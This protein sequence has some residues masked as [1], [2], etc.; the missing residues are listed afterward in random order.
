M[1]DVTALHYDNVIFKVYIKYLDCQI[2]KFYTILIYLIR[3]YPI[4]ISSFIRYAYPE[5]RSCMLDDLESRIDMGD[6]GGGSDEGS[7]SFLLIDS[8]MR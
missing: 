5:G 7:V 3:Y 1:S 6:F 8:Q 2:N 4:D